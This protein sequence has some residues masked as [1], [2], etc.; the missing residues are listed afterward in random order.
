M[1]RERTEEGERYTRIYRRWKIGT[2]RKKSRDGEGEKDKN[3]DNK[4]AEKLGGSKIQEGRM[5]I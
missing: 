5:K 4:G 3:T 2:V 1:S